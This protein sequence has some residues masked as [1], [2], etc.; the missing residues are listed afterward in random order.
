LVQR[1]IGSH[2]SLLSNVF[3]QINITHHPTDQAL[4]P[5]LVLQDQQTVGFLISRNRA[6]HQHS[7]AFLLRIGSSLIQV[8]SPWCEWACKSA[9][10]RLQITAR[11]RAFQLDESGGASSHSQIDR[12]PSLRSET[13][14]PLRQLMC[15]VNRQAPGSPQPDHCQ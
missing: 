8:P 10:F 9:L 5:A 15:S 1:T 12:P 2:K 4:N 13:N 7:I 3:N 14:K 6:L 11:R